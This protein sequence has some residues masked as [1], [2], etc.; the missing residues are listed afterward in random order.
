MFQEKQGSTNKPKDFI[1]L[2]FLRFLLAYTADLQRK[3][4]DPVNHLQCKGHLGD[5]DRKHDYV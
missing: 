4:E 5:V 2:V 3:K 1:L